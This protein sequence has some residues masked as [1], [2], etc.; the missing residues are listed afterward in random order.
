[1]T[2]EWYCWV[3]GKGKTL[4]YQL[5]ALYD[6]TT[7]KTFTVVITPTKSL[8]KDQVTQVM[9]HQS[10]TM[11][12]SHSTPR[13]QVNSKFGSDTALELVGGVD[14]AAT[15]R[16]LAR[17]ERDDRK[18]LLYC[19]PEKFQTPTVQ[20]FLHKMHQRKAISRFVLVRHALLRC[21]S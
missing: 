3:A 13:N 21:S 14:K 1:M 8:K 10:F 6:N 11:S 7:N 12:H 4:L 17:F 5:P 15:Q 20:E 19:T 9:K 16:V 2:G 18:P